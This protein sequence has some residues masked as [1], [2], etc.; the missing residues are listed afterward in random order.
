MKMNICIIFVFSVKGIPSTPSKPDLLWNLPGSRPTATVSKTGVGTSQSVD[1]RNQ[2][3]TCK[4][5]NMAVRDYKHIWP[6]STRLANI[7]P[8]YANIMATLCKVID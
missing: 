1:Y 6:D 7:W 4:V 2:K 8:H 5:E 3:K